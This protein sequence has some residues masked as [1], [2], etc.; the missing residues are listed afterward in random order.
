LKNTNKENGNE[1]APEACSGLLFEKKFSQ[2]LDGCFLIFTVKILL[3]KRY[4]CK[5]YK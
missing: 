3:Q 4:K 2:R 1:R 5:K